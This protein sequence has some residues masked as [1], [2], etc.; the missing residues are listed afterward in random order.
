LQLL[1]SAPSELA[2]FIVIL[3]PVKTGGYSDMALSEPLVV[4]LIHSIVPVMDYSHWATLKQIM[5]N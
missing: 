1:Y 5:F 2:T 4:M 3:P